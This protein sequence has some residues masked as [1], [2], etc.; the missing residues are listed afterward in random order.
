MKLELRAARTNPNTDIPFRT[1]IPAAAL[2]AASDKVC[3]DATVEGS[4]TYTGRLYIVKGTIA[5]KIHFACDRCLAPSEAEL[6]LPLWEEYAP[7]ED[8]ER[9]QVNV[10]EG[11]SIDLD[12]L[13]EEILTAEC[14]YPRYC[15]AECRGL[16]PVCGTDRNQSSCSCESE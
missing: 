13:V 1:V 12:R 9:W 5:V 10:L 7:Q 14:S 8:P 6:S 3:E 16:C 15:K 2:S 4:L 11:D